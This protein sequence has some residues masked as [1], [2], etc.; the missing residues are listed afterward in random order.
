MYCKR[1]TGF[2]TL[3][4]SAKSTTFRLFYAKLYILLSVDRS[5]NRNTNEI[6][7]GER[8]N[9]QIRQEG[10]FIIITDHQSDLPVDME[11]YVARA[12]VHLHEP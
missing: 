10:L 4:N 11:T 3:D 9:Y 6:I 7:F 5:T 2:A 8:C 1:I 12:V